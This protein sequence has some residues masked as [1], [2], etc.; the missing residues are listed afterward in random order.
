MDCHTATEAFCKIETLHPNPQ[1]EASF[2]Q[3]QNKEDETSMCSNR[4]GSRAGNELMGIARANPRRKE[5]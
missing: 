5:G 4:K 1:V 3:E 2:I